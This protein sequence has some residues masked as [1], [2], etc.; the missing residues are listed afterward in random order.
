MAALVRAIIDRSTGWVSC[1]FAYDPQTISIVKSIPGSRWDK[2]NK[3][4]LVPDHGWAILEKKVPHQIVGGVE[5]TDVAIPDVFIERLRPYQLEAATSMVKRGGSLLTFDPRVG[6]TP[7]AI[8]ALCALF[9][10][11]HITRAFVTYP[12]GVAGE[13]ERQL[14]EWAGIYIHK[15]EGHTLFDASEIARLRAIPYAVIGC[16]YEILG[17]R[18]DIYDLF[19]DEPFAWIGDEIHQ[20]KNRKSGRFKIIEKLVTQDNC[21][22]R[23]GLTGTPMR[24]RPRD[25]WAAFHLTNPGS[26]GWYWSFA[27]RYCEAFKG[28]YGWVDTG[29]SNAEELHDRLTAHSYRK[30]RAEVAEWL[31]KSDRSVIACNV[32]VTLLKKYKKLERHY[33]A[34][35]K[36]ALEDAN[37]TPEA[38]EALKKLAAATSQAKIPT[39]KERV[40]YH[41]ERGVKVIVFGH[42]HESIRGLEIEFEKDNQKAVEDGDSPV[43]VFCAGGWIDPK[44][45]RVV[46]DQWKDCH[47]PAVLLANS[48]S[49]G[50]GIDLADAEVAI[51]LELE[52]VPADFRQAEDRIQDVHLGKRTSPPIYEYLIVK[53]TIDEAMAG[54]ILSKV[55]SIEA[56]VGG[57]AE[58]SGVASALRGAGVVGPAHLGLP[59]TDTETVRAALDSLRDRWLSDEEDDVS[60]ASD[61]LAAQFE[62][63]WDDD[64]EKDES[65]EEVIRE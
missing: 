50:V 3:Q 20:V 59:S 12:A 63:D 16:H 61:T 33:A 45:R 1:K 8:S 2:E 17:K 7:T 38:R 30:T 56:V 46:I 13:W 10:G 9:G 11:G 31:P 58:T 54:A 29:I 36:N 55:R 47:T 4:W 27:K 62:D 52:W 53:D 15:L 23:Y 18:E 22:A 19:T 21:V 24:N 48:L 57:D 37:D 28:E 65:D 5:R 40:L 43:A 14:F 41:L 35:L 32:P 44:K 60:D 26:M 49:S 51:F 6:K 34:Q 64:D 42:F 39:A 25:I